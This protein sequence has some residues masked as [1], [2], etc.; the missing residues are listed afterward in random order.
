M[1]FPKVEGGAGA[2]PPGVCEVNGSR[3]NPKLEMPVKCCVLVTLNASARNVS[4]ICSVIAKLL[5][6]PKSILNRLG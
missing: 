1:N 6:R 3:T 2:A 5:Y 4:L